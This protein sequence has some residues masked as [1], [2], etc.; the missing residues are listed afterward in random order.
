[1][2]INRKKVS[3]YLKLRPYVIVESKSWLAYFKGKD[4]ALK[5]KVSP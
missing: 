4:L 3:K 5:V 2:H 1:M